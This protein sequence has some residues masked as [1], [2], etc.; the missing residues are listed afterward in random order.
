[1]NRV[2]HA[3]FCCA[4]LL[5]GAV[6]VSAQVEHKHLFKPKTTVAEQADPAS[7]LAERRAAF[8]ART[9][10]EQL[11]AL[12][13]ELFGMMRLDWKP[14][15][16]ALRKAFES[17]VA[18]YRAGDAAGALEGYKRFSI[19]RMMESKDKGRDPA[20]RTFI[21]YFSEA[22]E[23]MKGVAK[24]AV[25]D[26]PY[27]PEV[28]SAGVDAMIHY[29]R[30]GKHDAHH[31]L[32][33]LTIGEPGEVNWTYS[34]KKHHGTT[35]HMPRDASY[36][37]FVFAGNDLFTPLLAGYLKSGDPA[38]LKRWAA[39]VDDF[40]LNFIPDVQRTPWADQLNWSNIGGPSAAPLVFILRQK[41]E[42]V[43][44]VPA[45]T[46]ARMALHG[47]RA[48]IPNMIQLSRTGGPNRRLTM[49]GRN[50]NGYFF[51][52]PELAERDYLLRQRRRTLEDHP[53]VAIHPDGTDQILALPY[54]D[55]YYTT[56]PMDI[57]ELKGLP[58]ASWLTDRWQQELRRN[59][60][61]VGS[62]MLRGKDPG[63]RQ[64]A[65]RDPF[66]RIF[67]TKGIAQNLANQVP[68]VMA[69][70]ENQAILAW[71]NG[72]KSAQP[73]LRSFA[74][75]YGGYYYIWSDW[76][77][78]PQYMHLTSQRPGTRN[79]WRFN[80][81]IWLTAYNQLMLFYSAHDYVLEV[82]GVGGVAETDVRAMPEQTPQRNRWI[83]SEHFDFVEG[84][85]TDDSR[86]RDNKPVG[87]VEH[88][89][90]LL[91]VRDAGIWIVTDRVA[92]QKPHD[93]RFMWPFRGNFEFPAG[94]IDARQRERVA[95][96]NSHLNGYR[97]TEDF[98]F[99][100]KANVI[101][102]VSPYIPNLSIYHASDR[103]LVLPKGEFVQHNWR[104][105]NAMNTGPRI[106]NTERA[107][108]ASLIYPRAKD[109]ADLASFEAVDQPGIAGFNAL[110][111]TGHRVAYRVSSDA[112]AALS[113]GSIS[114]RGEAL[115]LSE[116]KGA[117]VQRGVLLGGTE[118]FVG[119][120]AQTLPG[121]DVAFE[122]TRDG[123]VSFERIHY[124]MEMVTISPAADR[125]VGEQTITLSHPESD[126]EIRY[127]LDGSMPNLKSP[128]YTEPITITDTTW[129]TAVAVRKGLDRWIDSTDSTK[130]SQPHWAIYEKEAYRAPAVAQQPADAKSGLKAVYKETAQP[131]SMINFA[132]VPPAKE[133]VA[134]MLFDV[135]LHE[136][137]DPFHNYGFLYTGYLQ[138]AEDGVYNFHAPEEF[139]SSTMEAWY[140]LR[141]FVNGEEWYPATRRQNFGTWS[142]P[143]KA[144]AHALEVRWVDQRPSMG[145]LR[146]GRDSGSFSFWLGKTP[147]L[148][149]SGPNLPRG[150]IP[151]SMLWHR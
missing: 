110:T 78:S 147:Q 14:E 146:G 151:A 136:G 87:T 148:D 102:T 16:E 116:A 72:D 135:S 7:N 94:Y 45:A 28:E 117:G 44:H 121:P 62:Y 85:M 79:R 12:A 112:A 68:E 93:F 150:P 51:G 53:R 103:E 113:L 128:V 134:P 71:H 98:E 30:G 54:Y 34:L 63:G 83:S 31:Q 64:P 81:N 104:F 8:A 89:R 75:P 100:T 105:G 82:D 29:Y 60:N 137:A 132:V 91:H 36:V 118:L 5:A 22:D 57:A 99:D 106:L 139:V 35:W 15:S 108:L 13:D 20:S 76:S 46:L 124:P 143:L 23:L 122:V 33:D 145:I 77:A 92:G 61:L 38:Y 66:R 109:G 111:K 127:T 133:G 140:D 4:V 125:F 131:I 107:V 67:D 119:A 129:I 115:L 138:V 9:S 69:L 73:P 25:F 19:Q 52:N 1:M 49:Y 24:I 120:N 40:H 37:S 90:Q 59:Q 123:K 96:T 80:N 130:Y 70:P 21:E 144:G 126:V 39:Y 10:P 41:P 101:R 18:A 55:Q 114:A 65:H 58:Q 11:K 56:P 149:V 142:I 2:H 50:M 95:P 84:S 47:W 97:P 32:L 48:G 3:L 43:E 27:P 42:A 88:A 26:V 17:A 6:A 86:M 74:Y 141:L